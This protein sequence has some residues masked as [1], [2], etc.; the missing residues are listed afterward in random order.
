MSTGEPSET[1]TPLVSAANKPSGT[2]STIP[3]CISTILLWQDG[4]PDSRLPL[5]LNRLLQQI[6]SSMS[7]G[8][9]NRFMPRGSPLPARR[10]PRILRSTPRRPIL[11]RRPTTN[12][13]VSRLLPDTSFQPRRTLFE[14]RHDPERKGTHQMARIGSTHTD[15][16]YQVVSIDRTTH[17]FCR[18]HPNPHAKNI[19]SRL[20]GR[21]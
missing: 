10:L 4:L 15:R 3:G 14:D 9:R 18:F 17:F 21:V 5:N 20:L 11:L 7:T 8:R 19:R 12:Y 1:C 6:P 16:S 13:S 2:T